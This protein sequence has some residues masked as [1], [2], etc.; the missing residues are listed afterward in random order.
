M[1]SSASSSSASTA[2]STTSSTGSAVTAK[3]AFAYSKDGKPYRSYR[4]VTVNH[5]SWAAGGVQHTALNKSKTDTQNTT[6]LGPLRAAQKIFDS[7]C[8][9]Q[10][11]VISKP[12]P[13]VIQ[14]TTRG[15]Q[16]KLY[17]YTGF[18][19]KL[20][21]PRL[22]SVTNKKT[23]ETNTVA[24]AHR[25]KVKALRKVTD[26]AT[27]AKSTAKAA[28]KMAGAT[29]AKTTSAKASPSKAK[30]ATKSLAKKPSKAVSKAA[31]KPTK[32]SAAVKASAKQ[33]TTKASS[34]TATKAAK[35]KV[36]SKKTK[37]TKAKTVV[38]LG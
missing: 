2:T 20:D 32:P 4:L 36:T 29:S 37:A 5:T 31:P 24:Y 34:K 27:T 11:L 15:K 19:E 33:T 22:V 7:W 21:Q 28:T 30:A 17:S 3:C 35:S 38:S 9:H 6:H 23:N 25:S 16:G 12:T 14:E 8:R 18:R 10:K 26:A 1:S 13:F